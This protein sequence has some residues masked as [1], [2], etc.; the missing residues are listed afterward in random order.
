MEEGV[1]RILEQTTKLLH[2]YAFNTLHN[3]FD[4]NKYLTV[5][6]K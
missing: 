2:G 1:V 5:N 4:Y 3:K 6:M